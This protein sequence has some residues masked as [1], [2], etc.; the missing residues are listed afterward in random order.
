M[1]IFEAKIGAKKIKCHA[2]RNFTAN[3][4]KKKKEEKRRKNEERKK[5]PKKR[6]RLL[7]N[8]VYFT[9]RGTA[10][11]FFRKKR[12][13]NWKKNYGRKRIRGGGARGE[14]VISCGKSF[15]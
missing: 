11:A 10:F 13:K 3:Q 6:R 4:H 14:G 5:K 7:S 9:L 12:K 1:F 8:A 15:S 2:E